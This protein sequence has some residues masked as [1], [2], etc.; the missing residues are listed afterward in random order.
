MGCVLSLPSLPP[1]CTKDLF[2]ETLSLQRRDLFG[3]NPD[4]E[5]FRGGI[6]GTQDQISEGGNLPRERNIQPR[7]IID[8]PFDLQ[9]VHENLDLD[10]FFGITSIADDRAVDGIALLPLILF[11]EGKATLAGPYG[12]A[13][14]SSFVLIMECYKDS[15][16]AFFLDRIAS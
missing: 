12:P 15:A 3:H 2:E 11:Q 6:P 1:R 5:E 7:D 9:S 14:P 8:V 13:E 16:A 10:P 4:I